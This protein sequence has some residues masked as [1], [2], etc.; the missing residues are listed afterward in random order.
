M[1]VVAGKLAN[2]QCRICALDVMLGGCRRPHDANT[3]GLWFG[4]YYTCGAS[5]NASGQLKSPGDCFAA[6]WTTDDCLAGLPATA[7]HCDTPFPSISA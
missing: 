4:R 5:D 1:F 6:T 7:T 2:E 3:V